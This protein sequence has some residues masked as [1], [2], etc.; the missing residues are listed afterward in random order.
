MVLKRV[1]MGRGYKMFDMEEENYDKLKVWCV[2]HKTT[3][4]KEINLLIKKFLAR[5]DRKKKVEE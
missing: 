3:I 5:Q 2:T 1:E 4:R